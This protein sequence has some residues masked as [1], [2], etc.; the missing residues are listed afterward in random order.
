MPRER[1]NCRQL[2][3]AHSHS[4]KTLSAQ[5]TTAWQG[6]GLPPP[7]Q[8]STPA[9]GTDLDQVLSHKLVE[10]RERNMPSLKADTQ[11]KTYFTDGAVD[12]ISHTAGDEFTARDATKSKITPSR[13]SCNHGFPSPCINSKVAIDSLQHSMPSD[14]YL[15]TT[16]IIAQRT[17][18]QVRIIILCP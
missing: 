15:L 11:S 12:P 14:I 7:L 13:D 5:S 6:H 3:D 17:L 9:V 4:V 2:G 1:P 8:Y 10:E 18:V 16:V